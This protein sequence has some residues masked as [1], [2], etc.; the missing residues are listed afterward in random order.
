M[1]KA[2]LNWSGG[3]DSALAL[4]TARE[5]QL[6]VQALVTTVSSA[7][8]RVTMHGVRQELVAQQAA[9]LHLPLRFVSLPATPGMAA[10]EESIRSANR[11]L[12]Q[13]QFTHAVSGDIFL[14]DLKR[15][16][17]TLY[18][19]DG[20]KT[21]FPLWKKDSMELLETF[22]ETGFK[23]IVVCVNAA[24]LDQRFCGRMLDASF[25]KDLPPG[26]DPCGENGEYHSF[27]FDGPLFSESVAFEQ[28]GI[29]YQE[30]AAP[31]SSNDCFSTPQPTTGFYFLD[32]LPA[33][34]GFLPL[35]H[36]QG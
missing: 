33:D 29:V 8:A 7:T 2:F 28:G 27:V 36:D 9:A 26:V 30:Y 17:E 3:K 15:Y 21:V 19:Q 25:V 24:V 16:R 31:R 18:A 6:N 34:G 14:E 1:I 35:P 32:L 22:W 12:V 13:Q 4:Y 20:I 11:E 10:Y 23:A 5:Q